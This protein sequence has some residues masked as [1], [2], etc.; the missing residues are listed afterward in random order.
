MPVQ[1][2]GMLIEACQYFD[3][4]SPYSTHISDVPIHELT[5]VTERISLARRTSLVT[6]FRLTFELFGHVSGRTCS[7]EH[8]H[9][10]YTL[11]GPSRRQ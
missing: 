10:G 3:R 6:I 11:A 2:E 7:S 9:L 4:I 1:M 5:D 8:T